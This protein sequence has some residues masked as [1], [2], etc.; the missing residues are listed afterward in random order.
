MSV[1]AAMKKTSIRYYSSLSALQKD[2]LRQFLLIQSFGCE[3]VNM[4][5]ALGIIQQ[6]HTTEEI[7]KKYEQIDFYLNG[8]KVFKI[9]E[10]Y[11]P[12]NIKQILAEIKIR[13]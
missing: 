10:T 13:K 1:K 4:K 7:L 8:C 2:T 5:L 6:A 3:G 12:L 9:D 11:Y